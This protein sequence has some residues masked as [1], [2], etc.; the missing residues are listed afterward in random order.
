MSYCTETVYIQSAESLEEEAERYG[1]IIQALGEQIKNVA[2]GN[3]DVEEYQLDDGQVKIRT[4]YRDITSITAAIK[5]F[6]RL[7]NQC[8][9]QLNGRST[10]LRPA[11]GLR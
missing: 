10:V 9:N 7:R 3:A 1:Q 2:A 11:R 4:K 6:K 8:I 5:E